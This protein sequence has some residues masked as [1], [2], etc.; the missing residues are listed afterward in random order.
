M[1]PSATWRIER[2]RSIA[3][4]WIQQRP[5]PRDVELLLG[6]ALGAIDRLACLQ[7]LGEVGDL[8]L[9]QEENRRTG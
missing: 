3:V 7:A 5:R 8:G 6:Q 2:R 4:F 1:T 9:Q